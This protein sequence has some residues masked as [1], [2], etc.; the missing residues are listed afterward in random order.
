MSSCRLDINLLLA[1]IFHEDHHMSTIESLSSHQSA[2]LAFRARNVRS[3]REDLELTL[4]AT[5]LAEP[6]VRRE[7]DVAGLTKPL[8][9]LPSAGLF[10]ANASG[11][12][13]VLHAMDDMRRLVLTSFRHGDRTTGVARRPFLLDPLARS[14]SSEFHV[15]LVLDGVRWQYGFEVDDDRVVGEYAYYSPKGRQALVFDRDGD[16]VRFGPSFRSPGRSLQRL[17][18]HNALL[19]SV[20]GTTDDKFLAPLFVWFIENMQLAEMSS[21]GVRAA[22]TAKMMNEPEHRER[23][24]ALLRAAELGVVNAEVANIDIDPAAREHIQQA[25]RIMTGT[26][27]DPDSDSDDFRV[28]DFVRLIHQGAH[29]EAIA[30]EPPDE[31][32]GTSVWVGLIGPVID[33]LDRGSLLLAD[34]LDAS[35]HPY[36]V[37]RLIELFQD[38]QVNTR[39]AQ[40]IFNAHDVSVLGDSENRTLGRDQVWFTEKDHDG[41]TRLYPLSDFRPRRDEALERR[42]LQGRF[43]GV[44]FLNPADFESAVSG[45]DLDEFA[46]A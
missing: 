32:E 45:G 42:Y 37:Q 9:V 19:L 25:V 44:P 13:R 6:R 22:L 36:L 26:D 1:R 46:D 16:D 2:L 41:T 39:C 29:G 5:R 33:A 21:R 35:L 12:S 23:V 3:Y 18:R 7:L 34:E 28:G 27:G 24:L 38:P 15:D 31:S 40:L 8:A 20:A 43:G 14:E 4:L 30:F 17:A 11:K 10:G